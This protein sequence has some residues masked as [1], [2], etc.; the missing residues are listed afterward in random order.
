MQVQ[1]FLRHWSEKEGPEKALE[2]LHERF[3][4]KIANQ[5]NDRV[6]LNYSMIE[7]PKLEQIVR[8]CRGLIL[9]YP[10]WNVMSR[11]FDRFF[12][13]GETF[14]TASFPYEESLV[15]EKVDGS[16]MP[17]Y[18]D[19]EWQIA[20]RGMAY[21]E[22][23][24]MMRKHGRTY[25]TVFCEG[26][27]C[28]EDKLHDFVKNALKGWEDWIWI[29]EMASPETRVV[30]SYGADPAV[31][32]LGVRNKINGQEMTP[33]SVIHVLHDA[34]L[35]KVRLPK[36]YPLSSLEE[37]EEAARNLESVM[38]EGFVCYHPST[39]KRVKVKSLTYVAIHKMR[40]NGVIN[41]KRIITIITEN[42][43]DEYFQ[44]FPE[45][46]KL[47]APYQKAYKAMLADIQ[48]TWDME[49]DDVV[50]GM[51][52]KVKL[53]DMRRQKDYAMYVKDKPTQG[54]LFKMRQLY[55]ENEPID[56]GE[57]ID[58]LPEK[59]KTVLVERYLEP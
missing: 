22:G 13:A 7:S 36:C 37:I 29:F 23:E 28:D 14:E 42:E 10:D 21:A 48:D 15:W 57:M 38:D 33:D 51:M 5:Y 32:L 30:K 17:M 3:G 34:G 11:T 19:G 9:S 27:G 50:D 16:L 4:I 18:F 8:E 39:G 26:F 35:T 45:D 31:Y 55:Q 47:F 24:T 40:D 2:R 1:D 58:N 52:T 56:I 53:R 54:I 20:T 41:P 25:R 6:V 44:Y 46:K 59:Q 12:N 49:V 43:T